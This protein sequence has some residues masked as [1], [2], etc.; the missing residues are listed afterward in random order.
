MGQGTELN[1]R[2][3]ER[4]PLV[5]KWKPRGELSVAPSNSQAFWTVGNVTIQRTMPAK[6]KRAWSI[7]TITIQNC[8]LASS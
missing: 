4:E 5:E 7:A 1:G 2:P 6:V 3:N 8:I